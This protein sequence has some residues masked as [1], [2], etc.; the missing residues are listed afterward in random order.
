MNILNSW[1]P[2][3]LEAAKPPEK[4]T[5]SGWACKYRELG[6]LSA[7]S[8]L[9]SLDMAPF[10]GPIMDRC[11]SPDVDQQS[12]CAAAQIG[13]TVAVVENIAGYYL[14]QDPSSLMVVLADEDTA[15]FVATEKIGPMFRDSAAMSHLY[16]KD[17]FG[18]KEINTPNGGHIDFAWASSVGKLA[19]RPERIVICDEVDKPGYYTKSKEASALSLAQERTKSYPDGFYKHIFCSTPTNELGNIIALAD[20]SDILLDWHV[21]C[22]YCGQFQP[23]RWSSEYCYGFENGQYR[24]D[25]GKYHQIGCVVWEGG[26]SAT[27]EQIN[28]TARYKC[29]E[30]GELWDTYQKNDA[31]RQGKEVPRFEPMGTPRKYWNHINRIYSLFDSGK[32]EKLVAAWVDIYK[33]P[34]ENQAKELQGFINSALAEPFKIKIEMNT[35]T[36]DKILQARVDLPQQTVPTEA[37]ALV[38]FVDVQKYGFWFAVRAFARDFTSWGIHFDYLNTWTEVQDLIS[39]TIY[40]VQGSEK[41]MRIWRTAIDTGGGKKYENMSMTEETYHYIRDLRQKGIRVWATKGNPKPFPGPE[42]LKVGKPLEKTPSGKPMPG[43]LKIVSLDTHKLKNKFHSRLQSAIENDGERP[44]YLHQDVGIEYARQILAEEL[45]MDEQGHEEWVPVRNDNH[46]L[47]CECGCIALA[48]PEW[49]GGGVNLIAPI[50]RSGNR[51]RVLNR[52]VDA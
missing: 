45:R 1:M 43:G 42:I 52:G 25:D 16:A 41:G 39:N 37:A 28:R 23:L 11:S 4:L 15:K 30:C 3:E 24:G 12:L 10:F 20:S 50:Q 17:Q 22:P 35:A 27:R 33:N 47:D 18:K 36:E 38:C 6:K 8:G 26:R 5:I 40:P 32:L 21:P 19:T 31:V 9:Y 48:E 49:E 14:H 7:I 51:R 2:E 29:G 44:A 34:K 46:W 13:K